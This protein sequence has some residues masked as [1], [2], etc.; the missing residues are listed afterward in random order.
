MEVIQTII[1]QGTQKM[2]HTLDAIK[3]QLALVRTA[4]ANPSVLNGIEVTYYG[5]PTPLAH[6]ATISTPEAQMLMIKPFDPSTLKD[7]EKA[8]LTSNINLM[9]QSDGSVIRLV[10]P[11]LTEDR[12]KEIVKEVKALA[13]EG[14]VSIRNHRREMVDKIKKLEKDSE[15][16]E[17]ESHNKQDDIQKTTDD[18]IKKI[19][20]LLHEKEKS[21]ME[22]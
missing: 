9:P 16:S 22:I 20:D 13:E 4:K 14:R 11:A 1:E 2:E 12:R 3:K 15:I 17:D 19:D 5:T 18:Y 8:I 6:I 7:I 10:F 21:I